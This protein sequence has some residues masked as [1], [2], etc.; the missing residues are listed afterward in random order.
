MELNKIIPPPPVEKKTAMSR[1]RR[2]QLI[3]MIW[4]PLIFAILL[5]LAA[6]VLVCLPESNTGI[7][8]SSLGSLSF[9]W[10]SAPAIPV[11]LIF[12]ALAGVLVYLLAKFLKILPG[13]F[14]KVQFYFDFGAKKTKEYADKV[15]APVITVKSRQASASRLVR[16]PRKQTNDKI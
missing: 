3:W 10:V 5:M 1:E 16:I 2:K 8:T 9:V 14:H 7:N 6:A 13:F 15:A 11:L 12:V 4:V